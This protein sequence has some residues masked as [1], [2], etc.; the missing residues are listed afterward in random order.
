VKHVEKVAIAIEEISYQELE[1]VCDIFRV[2]KNVGGKILCAGNGG[3]SAI[4]S[5][6][7]NDLIKCLKIPAIC[8]T[9]NV[10]SLTAFSKE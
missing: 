5:H 3:S 8:L 9:D 1:E 7:V 2:A 10:P 4:A 6:F